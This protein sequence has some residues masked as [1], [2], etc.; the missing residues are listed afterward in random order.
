V[1][2]CC[3]SAQGVGVNVISCDAVGWV[4]M[5][6]HA[7]RWAG[8]SN[9]CL[10]GLCVRMAGVWHMHGEGSCRTGVSSSSAGGAVAV[11]DVELDRELLGRVGGAGCCMQR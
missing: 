3:S 11:Q 10:L 6:L 9:C 8:G 5:L 4:R 1:Y 7:V 2:R